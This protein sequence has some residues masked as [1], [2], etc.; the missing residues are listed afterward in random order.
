MVSHYNSRAPEANAIGA[1]SSTQQRQIYL[2]WAAVGPLP[3]VWAESAVA[4]FG[5]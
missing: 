3:L 5:F 2:E 1:R 4:Q